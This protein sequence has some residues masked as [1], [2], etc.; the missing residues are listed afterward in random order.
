MKLNVIDVL[1]AIAS[2]EA[3]MN[4]TCESHP[5]EGKT[6][7]NWQEEYILEQWK[8]E[9]E[10]KREAIAHWSHVTDIEDYYN[11]WLQEKAMVESMNNQAADLCDWLM[12][13]GRSCEGVRFEKLP[14]FDEWMKSQMEVNAKYMVA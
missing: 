7:L 6:D 11:D 10:E 14:T 4:S 13:Q 9:Q 1:N 3:S 12:G 5:L 2:E 8:K